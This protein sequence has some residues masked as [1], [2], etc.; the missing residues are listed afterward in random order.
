MKREIDLYDFSSAK[1][2]VHGRLTRL[3]K[4]QPRIRDWG[5][6]SRPS[7]IARIG[8]FDADIDKM[9]SILQDMQ[10]RLEGARVIIEIDD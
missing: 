7:P 10:R 9:E 1:K 5:C 8:V 6:S 4:I 3:R 2:S